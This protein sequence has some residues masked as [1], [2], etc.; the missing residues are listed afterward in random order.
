MV[1]F[2]SIQKHIPKLFTNALKLRAFLRV[3][4]LPFQFVGDV[5]EAYLLEKRN[6]LRYDGRVIYLEHVLNNQFDNVERR[7][8]IT[9][10][11]LSNTNPPVLYRK[12]EGQPSVVLYRKGE[13]LPS[14]RLYR[15]SEISTLDFTIFVPSAVLNSITKHQIRVLVNYYKIA[16]KRFDIQSI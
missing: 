12:S 3:L 7:I 4:L 16:G 10:A 9:D 14:I 2:D 6:K 13:Q 15:N 11:T 5:L 1:I 8:Y